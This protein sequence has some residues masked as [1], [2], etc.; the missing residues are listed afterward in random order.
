MWSTNSV[1]IKKSDYHQ[2]TWQ[3]WLK[4][5]SIYEIIAR[6][7]KECVTLLLETVVNT[8]AYLTIENASARG[9]IGTLLSMH[10][11]AMY[12]SSFQILDKL[13]V[14]STRCFY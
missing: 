1:F 14:I 3:D 7:I 9:S 10:V 4:A 6:V 13:L 5:V 8:N 2:K 11:A 12:G